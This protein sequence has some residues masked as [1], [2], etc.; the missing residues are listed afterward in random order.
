MRNRRPPPADVAVMVKPPVTCPP[1]GG[2]VICGASF[3]RSKLVEAGG[4]VTLQLAGSESAQSAA[5]TGCAPLAHPHV[6]ALV[7]AVPV[8]TGAGAPIAVPS[9]VNWTN[10]AV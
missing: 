3:A 10:A 1:F 2:A 4:S 9:A 7:D 5:V 8:V 6:V